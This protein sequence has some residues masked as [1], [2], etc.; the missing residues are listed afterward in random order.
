MGTSVEYY[1]LHSMLGQSR[2]WTDWKTSV[3]CGS[4]QYYPYHLP[5]Y[6][7]ALSSV[8]PTSECFFASS[9]VAILKSYGS[10]KSALGSPW[11]GL[12]STSNEP[13]TANTASSSMY[14]LLRSKSCVMMGL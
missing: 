12:K 4:P 9:K 5:P 1:I 7:L 14:L 10:S 13:L 6:I 8:V 11:N 2:V 3:S